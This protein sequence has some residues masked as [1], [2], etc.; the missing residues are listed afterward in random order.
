MSRLEKPLDHDILWAT[1]DLLLQAELDLLLKDA[2][3]AWH[4]EAF[5]VDSGA[6]ITTMPASRAK[7][8]NLP[9]RSTWYFSP[10]TP[11]PAR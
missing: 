10:S 1:G 9:C 5:R 7:A 3:G 11:P 8:L 2:S 4:Q 6:N